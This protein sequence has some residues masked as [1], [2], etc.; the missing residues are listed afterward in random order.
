V[1]PANR[2]V[3]KQSWRSALNLRIR[4][5]VGLTQDPPPMCND[6]EQSYFPI[7]AVARIVH[8]DLATMIIGGIGSLFLQMLHPHAM[9]GVAQHS[10]YQEDA[11]GRLL[12]TANFIGHTT[13]G[14]KQTA[15][16][17][18]ERVLAVHESVRGIADDGQ[19]YYAN[20]PHLLAWVHVCESLLFLDAY[21]A[22][23]TLHL[24][25]RDLDEY[26]RE[27]SQLA[28]D[29]GAEQPPTTYDEL[30]AQLE[31]FRPEC[32][33]SAD[34]VVARD[35]VTKGFVSTPLQ[36]FA[37]RRF[38]MASLT[39]MPSWAVTMLG[40][41]VPWLDRVAGRFITR[42]L[43]HLTRFFVPPAVVERPATPAAT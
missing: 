4:H 7:D 29:L 38:A 12:Q 9:A 2:P 33:L 20:D 18:I 43:C 36:R 40:V 1:S 31:A 11:T 23:G 35:F 42:R 27:M 19:P 3:V 15:Y 26:V 21:R 16:L 37:H 28:T 32:R 39:L 10:R 5:A 14:T 24:G 22:F 8:G 34:G 6:P 41:E 30:R 17:D 13:Y 25:T